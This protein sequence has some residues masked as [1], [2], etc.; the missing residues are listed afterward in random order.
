MTTKWGKYILENLTTG[1][2]KDSKVIYREYI[3]NACDQFKVAM[4]LGILKKNDCSVTIYIDPSR[5]Y[6]SIQDNAT[7]VQKELFKTTLGN[8]ADSNKDHT[9]DL[10]FR[11][12]GR[13]CGLAY[14]KTLIFTTSY[15]GEGCKSIMTIDAQ[16]MR[17]MIQSKEKYEANYILDTITSFD[18]RS[19]EKEK[20]Y[21]QVEMID[22]NHENTELL[23]KDKVI[24]YLSFVAPVPFKN[25]FVYS[26]KIHEHARDLGHELDEYKITVNGKQVFKEYHTN[27]YDENGNNK[28]KYDTIFDVAFQDFYNEN[29]YLIA[30][31]WYG[32]CDFDKSIP[33]AANPM[34][35]IRL[36][37]G[38]IEIGSNNTLQQLF[39]EEKGNG[40]FIGEVYAVSEKLIANSQRDYFNENDERVKFENLLRCYFYDYLSKIYRRASEAK[41]GFKHLTEYN[42]AVEKFEKQKEQGFTSEEERQ[43]TLLEVQNSSSKKDQAKKKITKLYETDENN[44][45]PIGKVLN[46]IKN[47]YDTT[48]IQQKTKEAEEKQEKEEKSQKTANDYFGSNLTKL[49]K[50]ERKLV[51]QIMAIVVKHTSSDEINDI[52]SEI[53]EE[54][55]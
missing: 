52:K 19:E 27:L 25:V 51:G 22:I 38:N 49:S 44:E 50:K 9:K 20:H 16:K 15:Y 26:S 36:R 14:C 54:F 46:N 10:G 2:Y 4:E 41:L 5:R 40:Y 34:W 30:W 7:G 47:R 6:I 39:K 48:V 33:K 18:E 28:K 1:L 23:D 53:T 55:S 11:G 29:G 42:N 3:Q 12:I 13:L 24:N 17:R 31:M 35:G 37:Q 43:Q 21:F 32:L 8:I 45:E